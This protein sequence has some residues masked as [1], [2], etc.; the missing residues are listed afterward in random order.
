MKRHQTPRARSCWRILP[1]LAFSVWSMNSSHAAS[2]F[3]AVGSVLPGGGGMAA[4]SRFS[5][6][7]SMDGLSPMGETAG[8][9][10]NIESIQLEEAPATAKDLVLLPTESSRAIRVQDLLANDR[11]ASGGATVT[12]VSSTT[13]LGGQ[14]TLAA[15]NI[16]YTPPPSFPAGSVDT[17]SY[18]V[19]DSFGDASIGLVV[20]ALESSAPA[21]TGV[22]QIGGG[23]NL[24]F[25]GLPNTAY[26]LQFRTRLGAENAWRDYPD[27]IQPLIQQSD[28][29]G[30][31]QFT[32]ATN[33]PEGYFRAV[34]LETLSL[35]AGISRAGDRVTLNYR[36]TPFQNYQWQFRASFDG[37][38]TWSD[39]PEPNRPFIQ[40]AN[41][42]GEF[43]FSAP[44][45]GISG[46]F[47]PVAL[48]P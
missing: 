13:P 34:A 20:L 9:T 7:G 16:T 21:A 8:A 1:I 27:S 5:S 14:V 25:R 41:R 33:L 38:S 10:V 2:R 6:M 31:A 36:G 30:L 32:A 24:R 15:G 3:Q 26:Q 37:G 17:F 29:T 23:I 43:T 22:T 42:D 28:P 35:G 44:I 18:K 40:R 12:L 46:F 11:G 4:S 39:F 47:R 19:T 48:E 45:V